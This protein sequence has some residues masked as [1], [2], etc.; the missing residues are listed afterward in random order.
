MNRRLFAQSFGSA[1]IFSAISASSALTENS[2]A[3]GPG[4]VMAIAAH[5]GD[6]MFTMGA[7]LAQQI[8]RGGKGILL[9]LSLGEK[10]APKNIPVQQYG[11]MQRAATEKAAH[12]IGADAVFFDYPDAEIPFDEE[13]SLRV[14]DAIREHRPDVVVTHWSGSWHKDH[15]NCHL[16]VRDAVFYAGLETLTRSRRAHAVSK[17]F[18]ADNWE[19]AANFVPDT[20][21]DIEAV[22]EKWV[23]ACDFYPMWRGQTGFFRYN[24]YYSS[25]AVMRGCLSGFRHAVALM[26]DSNQ[27]TRHMQSL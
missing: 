18:Y 24:D 8:E 27:R 2:V 19:D 22:Y 3:S 6:G 1:A 7:T 9:S 25:L 23:Q 10:G 20:Y 26:S 4:K 14:C 15:Q 12:L 11:D 16:I 5:P 21:V 13:S 17:I